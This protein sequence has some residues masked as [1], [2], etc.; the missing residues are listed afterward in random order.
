M[1]MFKKLVALMGL[2]VVLVTAFTTQA[3]AHHR[4]HRHHHKAAAPK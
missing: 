4:H 1:T 3:E 2:A